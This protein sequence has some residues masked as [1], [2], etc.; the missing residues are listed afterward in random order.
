[1]KY[2]AFTSFFCYLLWDFLNANACMM[3]NVQVRGQG[4]RG[5]HHNMRNIPSRDC[6][7]HTLTSSPSST[8][9]HIWV[10][11]LHHQVLDI[12]SYCCFILMFCLFVLLLLFRRDIFTDV[13]VASCVLRRLLCTQLSAVMD[14]S[15]PNYHVVQWHNV[16]YMLC[17]SQQLLLTNRRRI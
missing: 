10:L 17:F 9:A 1:M 6:H 5:G 15:N 4:A 3:F 8:S 14:E 12:I 2:S 13:E 16:L 11:L 7:T